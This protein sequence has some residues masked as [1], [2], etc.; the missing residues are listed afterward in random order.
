LKLFKLIFIQNYKKQIVYSF[1]LKKV[2]KNEDEYTFAE[3]KSPK[4]QAHSSI[5]TH[6]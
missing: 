2:R 3:Q 5:N 4:G 6:S 1:Q